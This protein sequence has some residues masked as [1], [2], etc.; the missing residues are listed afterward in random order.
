MV[1]AGGNK[2]PPEFETASEWVHVPNATTSD[3]VSTTRKHPIHAHDQCGQV[4]R[5]GGRHDGKVP[6]SI[7]ATS[8][9]ALIP[10]DALVTNSVLVT[11]SNARS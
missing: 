8:S 3:R 7:L 10:S 11:S 9:S 4:L 1:S 5:S 6:S 2:N